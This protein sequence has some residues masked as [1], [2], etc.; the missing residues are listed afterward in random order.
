M[1]GS[2]STA[3]GS[4]SSAYKKS[5]SWSQ[6][7]WRKRSIQPE[8]KVAK[9]KRQVS[10]QL[11]SFKFKASADGPLYKP[12]YSIKPDHLSR[13][14]Q[15]SN[16]DHI[17]E[18]LQFAAAESSG[19]LSLVMNDLGLESKPKSSMI[20]PAE[21]LSNKFLISSPHQRKKSITIPQ[22]I[23]EGFASTIRA[24]KNK[25]SLASFESH[26][27][28]CDEGNQSPAKYNHNDE[29]YYQKSGQ[30][31]CQRCCLEFA[32][33]MQYMEHCKVSCM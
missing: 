32:T 7:I 25:T 14:R 12:S 33:M 6:I 21:S 20:M 13:P 19:K 3:S 27:N 17:S 5:W 2:Y 10:K 29:L 22:N 9:R 26:G 24:L 11:E 18:S 28:P 1:G 23:D 8:T 16:R 4:N 31:Y 30:N 15:F